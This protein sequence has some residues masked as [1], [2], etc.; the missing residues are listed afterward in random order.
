LARYADAQAFPI[1]LGR[2]QHRRA[3]RHHVGGLDLQ[4]ARGKVHAALAAGARAAR[5]GTYIDVACYQCICHLA[6][7][8]EPDE[9]QGHIDA[10]GKLAHQ[11]NRYAAQFSA[12]R[13]F[14][15]DDGICVIDPGTQLAGR[16]EIG[17]HGGR[18]SR[19]ARARREQ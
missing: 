2:R 11:V 9:F 19:R 17:A 7:K 4:V 10:A 15:R 13:V 12:D 5:E 6:G 14:C 18:D 8:I 3:G 16:R 1:Y